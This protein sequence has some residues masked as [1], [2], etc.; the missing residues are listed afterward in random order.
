MDFSSDMVFRS[1]M[2]KPIPY[3]VQAKLLHQFSTISRNAK[4]Y[5]L[6]RS[7]DTGQAQFLYQ[8]SVRAPLKS[9]VRGGGSALAEPVG[10]CFQISAASPHTLIIHYSLAGAVCAF[11]LP[12]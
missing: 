10:L 7:L 3:R 5:G 9:C 6:F 4:R 11:G 1:G 12:Q 2:G 8:Y